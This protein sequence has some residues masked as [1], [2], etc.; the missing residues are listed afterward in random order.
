MLYFAVDHLGSGG[1]I[2]LTA[3]HNPAQYNGF[4]L[5]REHAIPVGE[6]SGLREIEKLAGE[7]APGH[8]AERPGSRRSYEVTDGYVEH[9]LAG[10]QAEATHHLAPLADHVRRLI[11]ALEGL[12]GADDQRK[13]NRVLGNSLRYSV[14]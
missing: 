8:V 5:C 7:L 12:G 1:G 6:A 9:V 2:M 14:R 11:H 3:S 10:T 13:R 4:K